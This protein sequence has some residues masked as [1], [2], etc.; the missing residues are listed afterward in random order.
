MSSRY[1]THLLLYPFPAAGHVIPMLDFARI[2]LLRGFTVTLLVTPPNFSLLHPLLSLF[3]SSFHSLLLHPPPPH[4]QLRLTSK[5]IALRELDPHIRDWFRSHPSPPL[6]II[7][8]FFLGWT[9]PLALS[10]GI[11]RLAFSPSGAFALSVANSLWR[12]TP[13]SGP[14]VPGDDRTPVNFHDL[15][16]SP[17]SEWWQLP[18]LYRDYRPGER[19]HDW[20][21]FRASW[22]QNFASWGTVVN[23]FDHLESK[24]IHH[25]KTADYGQGHPGRVWAVGPLLPDDSQAPGRGGASSLP[26]VEITRWLDQKADHSV[27]FVCFGSRSALSKKQVQVLGDALDRSGV[28][29]IFAVRA[30]GGGHSNSVADEDVSELPEDYEERVAGRGLVIRGWAPQV[31][32]LNHRAVGAFLSHCG[33]NSVLEGLS[34]GVVMLTWSM[35]TDQF[36]NAELL[37]EQVGVGIRVGESTRNIPE[38][39]ELATRLTQAVDPTRKERKRAAQ[40]RTEALAAVKGGS[41]EED[42]DDLV[43]QLSQLGESCVD[44]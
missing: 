23:T 7:S 39:D 8:D 4:Q 10:L 6:A 36:S 12:R 2:L 1:T 31:P 37:V 24:H 38:V 22:L 19:N 13:D 9:Q 27:V 26:S 16:G 44:S 35:G 33:W 34:A 11:K 17:V 41:S 43:A 29:F 42:L 40:V 25:L 32:I 21:F 28:C 14:S 15:P 18:L 5:L 30:P 20:D 3:P